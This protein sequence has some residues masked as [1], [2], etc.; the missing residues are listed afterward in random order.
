MTV[1]DL[2]RP[3][4]RTRWSVCHSGTD[5]AVLRSGDGYVVVEAACPHRGARLVDGAVRDGVLECPA[6]R[7]RF[8]LTTGACLTS[9]RYRLTRYPVTERG[10]RLSADLPGPRLRRW[11]APWRRRRPG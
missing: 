2:G 10:G 5:Y 9:E 3:K 4:G 11:P 7:Y 1:I 8:D 6:H